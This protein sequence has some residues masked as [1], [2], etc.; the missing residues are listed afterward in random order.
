MSKDQN[1]MYVCMFVV[2]IVE[3]M[4]LMMKY[5]IL[6]LESVEFCQVGQTVLGTTS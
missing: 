6:I 3:F 5:D 4:S 1:L 2:V